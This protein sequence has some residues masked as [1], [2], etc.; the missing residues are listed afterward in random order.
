M[1]IPFD[2]LYIVASYYTKPRMKLLDWINI[3]KLELYYLSENPNAIHLLEEYPDKMCWN[4]LSTNP[5]ALHLLEK[6]PNKINWHYLSN[7]PNAIHILEKNHH[8]HRLYF[9]SWC[10]C[11]W[12]CYC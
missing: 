10:Y 7:N 2:L 4:N 9:C 8:L 5:N 12:Y 3:D 11:F 6:Y 1:D